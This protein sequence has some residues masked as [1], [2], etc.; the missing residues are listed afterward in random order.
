MQDPT[1][2]S[3]LCGV[4]VA[5]AIACVPTFG[6]H[7]P[8]WRAT[9][10]RSARNSKLLGAAEADGTLDATA[11][12]SLCAVRSSITHVEGCSRASM[13]LRGD[14][15]LCFHSDGEGRPTHRSHPPVPPELSGANETTPVPF[16]DCGRYCGADNATCRVQRAGT[17]P[18]PGE[19][20]ILCHYRIER[21]WVDSRF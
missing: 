18:L 12:Q 9:E 2:S 5:A 20:F 19:V 11:C 3:V 10:V 4:L 1:P 17:P 15:L 6:H 21:H 8:G 7:T 14:H 13:E 16:S